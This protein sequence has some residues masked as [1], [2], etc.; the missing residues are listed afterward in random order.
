MADGT[1]GKL[2]VIKLFTAAKLIQDPTVRHLLSLGVVH[3][4]PETELDFTISL[5]YYS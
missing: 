5:G 3:T 2:N 4:S 1:P